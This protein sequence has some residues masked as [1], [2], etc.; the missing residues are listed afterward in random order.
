MATFTKLAAPPRRGRPATR[1]EPTQPV[2]VSLSTLN[3]LKEL[4]Q[5]G[6]T[7]DAVI[8]RLLPPA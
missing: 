2:R 1:T 7:L 6:E 8:V 3:R 4:A 5:P